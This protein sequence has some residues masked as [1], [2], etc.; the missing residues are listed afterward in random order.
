MCVCACARARVLHDSY[1]AV[2]LSALSVLS[3]V[4]V[5]CGGLHP[6]EW[7]SP[8][9]FVCLRCQVHMLICLLVKLICLLYCLYW[10]PISFQFWAFNLFHHWFVFWCVSRCAPGFL[11]EYC[12]HRDPCLPGFCQNGGNCTVTMSL[13]VP[14]PGS[15]TC[16]CPLGFTGPH[17]QT[18]QNSTCYPHNPCENQGRCTL[19]SLDEYKCECPVGWAG[20]LPFDRLCSFKS[21]KHPVWLL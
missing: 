11:G 14:V 5:W 17:C 18:T 3:V 16:S 9:C 6:P 12:Q 15:A 21:F 7:N 20:K 8:F 1:T 10:R 4:V 13:G 2:S 19:L